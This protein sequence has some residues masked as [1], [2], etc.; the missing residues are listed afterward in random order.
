[1]IGLA[2]GFL[3]GIISTCSVLAGLFFLKFWR[4]TRDGLFFAFGIAFLV[5]GVN[6]AVILDLPEPSLGHAFTYVVRLLASLIILA[7]ILHKN[8]LSARR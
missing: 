2:E 7:G 3:L 5:E 1:M 8:Y 6:R 4:R